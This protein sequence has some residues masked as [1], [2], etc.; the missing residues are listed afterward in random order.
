MALLGGLLL[1]SNKAQGACQFSYLESQ[2]VTG[3]VW[4]DATRAYVFLRY[5]FNMRW[6]FRS[7][8]YEKLS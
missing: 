5:F 6:Q 8:D 4:S 1:P 3:W 2:V 7:N